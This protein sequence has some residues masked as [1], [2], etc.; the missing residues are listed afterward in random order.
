[1]TH[2]YRE[3]KR[4]KLMEYLQH[5]GINF[6]LSAD[7]FAESDLLRIKAAVSKTLAERL[8]LGATTTAAPKKFWSLL[9]KAIRTQPARKI[10]SHGQ[11]SYC[12]PTRATKK[13]LS[14]LSS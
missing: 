7:W 13:M 2:W 11:S 12:P 5:A 1:M 6:V 14:K 9:R 3:P 4:V 10:R 8:M